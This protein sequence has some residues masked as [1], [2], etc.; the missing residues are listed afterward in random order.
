MR[1]RYGSVS[2]LSPI[3]AHVQ[4]CGTLRPLDG[5][6]VVRTACTENPGA[7]KLL[8]ALTPSNDPRLRTAEDP[9]PPDLRDALALIE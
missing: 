3:V 8:K 5:C 2:A 9:L 1:T 6:G 4:S 7:P